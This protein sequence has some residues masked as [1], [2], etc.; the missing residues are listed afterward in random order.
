MLSPNFSLMLRVRGDLSPKEMQNAL[1][2]IRVRHLVLIPS[3]ASSGD[4][5]DIHF[6]MEVRED[7]GPNAWIELVAKELLIP[8][9]AS[10]V[11]QARVFLLKHADKTID[12]VVTFNHGL[13]D[14]LSGVYFLRD[15]LQ[16]LDQP[17]AQLEPLPIPP[18]FRERVP[19]AIVNKTS[20]KRRLFL[21]ILMFKFLVT[22]A[23]IKKRSFGVRSQTTETT[24]ALPLNHQCL[25]MP[26]VLTEGQTT[27]LV[28]RCKEEGVTVHAAICAAWL[29][30]FYMEFKT[31]SARRL[32]S[33]PVNI[34]DRLPVKIGETSGTFLALVTTGTDASPNVNFWQ[35]AREFKNN[36]LSSLIED[37]YFFDMLLYDKVFSDFTTEEV[38]IVADMLFNNKPKYDFSITNLGRLPFAER[39]G[40]LSVDTFYGPLVNSSEHERTVGVSTLKGRLTMTYLLRRSNMSEEQAQALQSRVLAILSEVIDK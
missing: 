29:R 11:A 27:A 14:G 39:Y 7:S 3:A 19:D 23:R 6:P 22:A 5:P 18:S 9:E 35:T 8:F 34:R 32:V 28:N 37:N 17:T 24:N 26:T 20:I 25:I 36:F 2:A 4:L 10:G 1:D 40:S 38:D 21:T 12:I 15:L 31:G 16:A 33:S 30:A 13:C